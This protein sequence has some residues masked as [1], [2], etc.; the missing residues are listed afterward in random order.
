MQ[1]ITTELRELIEQYSIHFQG[2]SQEELMHKPSPERWSKKELIGHLC[3]SAQNNIQRFIR[4]QYYAEPPQ[5]VY[6]QDE[7]VEL[8]HYQEYDAWQLINFWAT[9]NLHLCWILDNMNPENY[10]KICNTGQDEAEL[11]SLEWLA[12]DY[13]NHMKHHLKQITDQDYQASYT[14]IS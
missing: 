3:D 7:W 11:H 2:L 5:I 8:A 1:H 6:H 4:G 13:V 14:P 10:S 12:A 9:L